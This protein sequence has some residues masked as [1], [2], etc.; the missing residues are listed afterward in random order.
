MSDQFE[1]RYLGTTGGDEDLA[2]RNIKSILL[3]ELELTI[4]EIVNIL[5]NVPSI[6][7]SSDNKESLSKVFHLLKQAGANVEISG[8]PPES[9]SSTDAGKSDSKENS[10]SPGMTFEFDLDGESETPA[11]TTPKVWSLNVDENDGGNSSPGFSFDEGEEPSDKLPE[12]EYPQSNPVSTSGFSLKL[13]GDDG[14]DEEVEVKEKTPAAA[15]PPPPT[16]SSLTLSTATP[17]SETPPASPPAADKSPSAPAEEEFSL[18]ISYDDDLDAAPKKKEPAPAPPPSLGIDLEGNNTEHSIAPAPPVEDKPSNPAASATPSLSTEADASVPPTQEQPQTA[19]TEGTEKKPEEQA[20]QTS[21]GETTPAEEAGEDTSRRR[22]NSKK[23]YGLLP[24]I[25]CGGVILFG[26]NWYVFKDD[27]NQKSGISI[28]VPG[29]S[30]SQSDGDNEDT[31]KSKKVKTPRAPESEGSF[32]TD[33]ANGSYKIRYIL[34]NNQ[35]TGFSVE[36]TTQEPPELTSLEIAEGKKK[37]IWLIHGESEIA[38]LK[39]GAACTPMR[40]AY[41]D[42]DEKKK[43][44]VESCFKLETTPEY[45]LN[46]TIA[47][48][49]S[50]EDKNN[51]PTENTFFVDRAD[52]GPVI[53]IVNKFSLANINREQTPVPADTEVPDVKEKTKN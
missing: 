35:F 20:Q 40:F 39:D 34:Q 27:I 31:D 38:R 4:D 21:A 37:K 32:Y 7:R 6:I 16:A 36:L 10:D 48:N 15:P 30:S 14:D 24:V 49:T 19:S 22:R 18:N 43:L 46:F 13:D 41:D 53:K 2:L 1:L 44:V 52:S 25:L 9:S 33:I 50:D 3:T 17:P 29:S 45:S 51:L 8:G 26:I 28:G 12:T 11:E 42:N 5:A 47:H 23:D